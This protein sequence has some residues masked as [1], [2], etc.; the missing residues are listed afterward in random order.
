MNSL[1]KYSM[2]ISKFLGSFLVGMFILSLLY[3]F[4]LSKKITNILGFLYLIIIF[5]IFGFKE[6]VKSNNRGII[7]GLKIGL[8]LITS[9]L[10]FNL[11]F[12]KSAFRLL[13]FI[14]YIILILSC[15]L[16]SIIGANT[17]KNKA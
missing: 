6:E 7:N 17:K 15:I 1:K 4:F 16:G 5:I 12:F 11:I 10:I 13:R 2:L 9:L 3:Y 8:I 14:Y